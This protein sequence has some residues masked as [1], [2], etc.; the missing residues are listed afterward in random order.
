[1]PH[2][3]N[4]LLGLYLQDIIPFRFMIDLLLAR[5]GFL[6]VNNKGL[7]STEQLTKVL[8]REI[9][10]Q[11][12]FQMTVQKYRHITIIIDW[13][14]ICRSSAEADEEDENEEDNDV[15]DLMAAH[16]TKLANACYAWMGGLFKGLTSEFI[17]MY[18]TVSDKWQKW[19]KLE[20]WQ[21][22]STKIK[23]AKIESDS[24]EAA[25]TEQITKAF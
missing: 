18:C 19:Y 5:H 6:F 24:N 21:N 25:V 9:S 17:N 12:G 8:T 13:E 16:L 1:M 14:F 20:S 10:K 3:I 15:H 22:T 23:V 11:L 2:C 4:Q 7:W